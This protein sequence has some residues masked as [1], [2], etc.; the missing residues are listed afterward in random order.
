MSADAADLHVSKAVKQAFAAARVSSS[1]FFASVSA[2][3]D[4]VSSAAVEVAPPHAVSAA[5]ETSP[6]A[7]DMNERGIFTTARRSE[8]FRDMDDSYLR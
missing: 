5:I 8:S 7:Y 6:A 2:W 1:A 4:A 3:A